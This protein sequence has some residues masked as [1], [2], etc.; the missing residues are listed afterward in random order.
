M[1]QFQRH[2]VV[3]G[4]DHPGGRRSGVGC[5]FSG[6]GDPCG[7]RNTA[8]DSKTTVLVVLKEKTCF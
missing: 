3:G 5:G 4:V 7:E 8:F 2:M 6:P 1:G